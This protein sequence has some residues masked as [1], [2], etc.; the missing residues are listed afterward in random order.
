VA[1][2]CRRPGCGHPAGDRRIVLN[3]GA[4]TGRTKPVGPLCDRHTDMLLSNLMPAYPNGQ[5]AYT[6]TSA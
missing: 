6:V 4:D 1:D 5:P 2:L 3:L